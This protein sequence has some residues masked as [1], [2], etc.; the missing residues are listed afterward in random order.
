[1]RW[2]WFKSFVECLLPVLGEMINFWT[3]YYSTGLNIT[4]YITQTIDWGNFGVTILSMKFESEVASR[5]NQP[6]YLNVILSSWSLKRSDFFSAG[7]IFKCHQVLV[8]VSGMDR[9]DDARNHSGILGRLHGITSNS[10]FFCT[11][12]LGCWQILFQCFFV[13]Q[14][15]T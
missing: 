12:D 6:R 14:D 13:S 7:V 2:W 3:G 4:N 11:W 8:H 10:G 5:T 15:R 1:M 9:K